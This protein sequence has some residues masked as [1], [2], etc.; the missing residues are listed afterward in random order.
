MNNEITDLLKNFDACM[1][2]RDRQQK[3]TLTSHETLSES[4]IK[5]GTDCL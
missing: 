4:W 1:T 2:Y 5:V 3:E